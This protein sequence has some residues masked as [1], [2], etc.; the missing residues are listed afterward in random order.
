MNGNKFKG[1][2]QKKGG[3][4]RKEVYSDFDQKTDRYGK[5]VGLE[6]GKGISVLLL[7]ST[8][9]KPVRAAIRGIHHKKVWFKKDDIVVVRGEEIWGK[10]NDNEVNRIRRQFDTIEGG[11]GDKSSIIFRD[12]NDFN[13]DDD[14][15]EDDKKVE[16]P[17][18]S[19]T[20]KSQ[21]SQQTQAAQTVQP[22]QNYVVNDKIESEPIDFDSI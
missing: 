14:D 6:G 4:T 5:I 19:S 21:K 7:D 15:E 16:N 13:D 10:V 8:D 9:G 17:K 12:V 2:K 22:K 18:Q 20:Q 1:N 11:K 3:R